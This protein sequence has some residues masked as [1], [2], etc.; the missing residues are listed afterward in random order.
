MWVY[1]SN[2]VEEVILLKF[3]MIHSDTGIHSMLRQACPSIIR[4]MMYMNFNPVAF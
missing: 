3:T 2:I 1:R 4:E